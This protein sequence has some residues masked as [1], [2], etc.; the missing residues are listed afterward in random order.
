MTRTRGAHI[1][2]ALPRRL[3]PMC[4]GCHLVTYAV[5]AK[6]AYGGRFASL[7]RSGAEPGPET[8]V[9]RSGMT[10]HARTH[11]GQPCDGQGCARGWRLPQT[12]AEP[13]GFPRIDKERSGSRLPKARAKR[14]GP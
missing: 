3:I 14:A 8:P 4:Q 12:S 7:D 10:V 1:S 2:L 6:A 11:R 9:P 5:K 13:T